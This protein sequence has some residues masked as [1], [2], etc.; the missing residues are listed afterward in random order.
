MPKALI[1]GAS[2]GI[3]LELARIFAREGYELALV[4]R[5][6]KRLE[7]LAAEL[8]PA[9]VQVIAKD[10]SLPDAPEEIQRAVPRVD[11]LVNNAG[12]GLYGKF[13]ATSLAEELNMMQLNMSAL[14]IL[15][16]LYLAGML[17]ARS[18]RILN[19]AS[20]AAFQPGPLMSIY[21]A[22]KA[23]VLSFSEAIG[24]ELQGSGVMV[25]ALCPGPT[26]TEF[27]ERAQLRDIA[28]LKM[29]VMDAR[30]VA[31]AGYRGML[32]GKAI[33]IPGLQ[34]KLLAQSLR[35]SPRSMV[36]K[37]VRRMQEQAH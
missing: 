24:N 17:A 18:G 20:T 11:V 35:F 4:A 21:Y 5:H 30:T 23:F 28:L 12:F 15:T 6:Q 22:T 13:A 26:A 27:Q 9:S 29:N 7:D 3:G 1:T 16:K 34:N 31:E 8:K 33:V 10:L 19:V 36:T 14:V 32:A 25:T 2:T 37:V